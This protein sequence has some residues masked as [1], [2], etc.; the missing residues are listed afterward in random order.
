ML[1]RRSGLRPPASGGHTRFPRI[2]F[3]S[4]IYGLGRG[5]FGRLFFFYE[6]LTFERVLSVPLS[7]KEVENSDSVE[8]LGS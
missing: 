6:L 4:T 8:I 5:R 1:T 3:N 7:I 2:E